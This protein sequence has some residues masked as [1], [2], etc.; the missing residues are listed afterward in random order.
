MVALVVKYADNI[1]K[2]FASSL[3]VVI[4]GVTDVFL[5]KDMSIDQPFLTG[6]LIV[7]ASSLVFVVHSVRQQSKSISTHPPLQTPFSPTATSTVDYKPSVSSASVSA[8]R[9][10]G[11]TV[12]NRKPIGIESTPSKKDIPISDRI[13]DDSE[14]EIVSVAD[15]SDRGTLSRN[16]SGYNLPYAGIGRAAVA[17]AVGSIGPY[18]LSASHML[19]S[20]IYRPKSSKNLTEDEN[21]QDV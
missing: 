3:S 7:L 12:T 16:S 18:V 13:D 17:G 14:S 11:Y 21:P 8:N 15:S 9:I 2:G 10:G 20:T 5:F 1:H 19:E 6:T 4:S